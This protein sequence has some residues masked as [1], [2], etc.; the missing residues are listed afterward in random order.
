MES[1]H[2]STFIK[3]S[4]EQVWDTMLSSASYPKWTN[5]FMAGSY[6]Q[7]NWEQGSKML[8]LAPNKE[9][10]GESGMVSR[11]VENRYPEFISIE[12]LGFVKNGVEDLESAEVQKWAGAH[13][14]YTFQAKDGGT[15]L[16]IEM[17]VS[18]EEKTYM[19][20]AWKK[21]L[22]QLKALAE[23]S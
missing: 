1:L 21:A 3:A 6:F 10:G 23:Q 17:N 18:Q 13:E 7:G 14:N 8:F 2:F 9:G 20:D 4:R 16:V 22:E 5:V 15:E 11:V 12:H 19:E